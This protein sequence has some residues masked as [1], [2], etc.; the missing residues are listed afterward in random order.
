MDLYEYFWHPTVRCKPLCGV[1]E[2]ATSR[3]VRTYSHIRVRAK[4]F[5]SDQSRRFEAVVS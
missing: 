5:G 3:K 1:Q 4:P 2:P